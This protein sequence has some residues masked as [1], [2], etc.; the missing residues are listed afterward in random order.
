MLLYPAVPF[1]ALYKWKLT[2]IRGGLITI[3]QWLRKRK[4]TKEN[5]SEA[6]ICLFVC[7]FYRI[8]WSKQKWIVTLWLYLS[9]DLNSACHSSKILVI[10]ITLE[11]KTIELPLQV[12]PFPMYPVWQRQTYDPMVFR[13]SAFTW[14][15]ERF[16]LHS[17]ISKES[18]M[19]EIYFKSKKMKRNKLL[20]YCR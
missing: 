12:V 8:P 15:E 6:N 13:Q 16:V 10:F 19:L 2:A 9:S 18:Q 14:Q 5:P 11:K 17:S 3:I 4:V 7:F 1:L 20:R